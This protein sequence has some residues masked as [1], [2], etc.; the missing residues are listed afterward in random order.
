MAVFRIED[1]ENTPGEAVE[2]FDHVQFQAGSEAE[3][4]DQPSD[5]S[6]VERFRGEAVTKFIGCFFKLVKSFFA[7]E[8]A[9]PLLRSVRFIAAQ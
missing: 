4:V 2:Q 8:A 7:H 6:P 3:R 9:N 5:L 1:A